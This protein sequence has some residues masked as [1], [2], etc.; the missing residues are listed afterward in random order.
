MSKVQPVSSQAFVSASQKVTD[1]CPFPSGIG[2][3][4][5]HQIEDAGRAGILTEETV[6][7]VDDLVRV[8]RNDLYTIF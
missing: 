7:N 6:R 1:S 2:G 8:L 3:S 5:C 4:D